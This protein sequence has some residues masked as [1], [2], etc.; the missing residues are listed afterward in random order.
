MAHIPERART[1]KTGSNVKAHDR[2]VAADNR[3]RER[4]GK[5][6]RRLRRQMARERKAFLTKRVRAAIDTIAAASRSGF[7]R[8]FIAAR[9]DAAAIARARRTVRVAADKVLAKAIPGLTAFRKAQL[10]NARVYEQLLVEQRVA[11]F[12]DRVHV[13][14][15]LVASDH[16]DD[17]AFTAPYPLFD[18]TAHPVGGVILQEGTFADPRIGVVLNQ[19]RVDDDVHSS[20]FGFDIEP[21]VSSSAAVGI[22][23]TVPRSGRIT[24]SAVIQNIYNYVTFSLTDNFGVSDGQLNFHIRLF[25]RIVRGDQVIAFDRL[26]FENGLVALGGT[27]LHAVSFDDIDMSAPYTL[28]ATTDEVF[29]AGETVQLLVGSRFEVDMDLNDMRARLNGTIGWQVKTIYARTS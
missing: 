23:Y 5:A 3:I 14:F 8:A 13:D 10:A 2:M 4:R 19:M 9:G 20:T 21:S 29:N 16:L 24:C 6:L 11:A 25:I 17:Q 7:N 18:V 28:S 22:P 1:A 15:D 12:D 26:I 27:D